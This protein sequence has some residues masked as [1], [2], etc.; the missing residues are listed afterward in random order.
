MKKI[1][2]YLRLSLADKDLGENGKDESNSIE[3]QRLLIRNYLTGHSEIVGEVVEYKDDGYTGLN[4]N[5]PAFRDMIEDAKKGYVGTIVVKDLS[6]FGRDYIGVGDYLEQI[7]PSLGV[8]LIAIN[9]RYDSKEQGASI[10]GMD[11]SITNLINNMY[12]KD[13]SKKIRSVIAA[14]W[15][16]GLNVS[17]SL[18]YGYKLDK[19]DPTHTPVIDDE[20]AQVVKRIFALAVDGYSTKEI[21]E[22]LNADGVPTPMKYKQAAFGFSPGKMITPPEEQLWTTH[23]VAMII[24][25]YDYTGARVHGKIEHIGVGL[26]KT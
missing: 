8:R 11:Y 17:A 16:Q 23:N 10:A 26:G 21:A 24:K 22:R 9:N 14:K 5:R 2:A 7:L 25:R 20:A 13:I 15:R 3:N 18:P 19:N 12:S 1:A 6:R 4:F